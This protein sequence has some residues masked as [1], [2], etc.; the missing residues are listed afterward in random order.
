VGSYTYGSDGRSYELGHGRINVY[1]AILEL[2]ALYPPEYPKNFQ[3]FGVTSTSNPIFTWS[4]NKEA[5]LSGY[6]IYRSVWRSKG[7]LIEE[8]KK[9]NS[10]LITSTTY[11]DYTF[12]KFTNSDCYAS[13]YVVAVDIT[14]RNSDP[15]NHVNVKGERIEA[16]VN[17]HS[18]LPLEWKLFQNCPNPFNPQ[19]TINYTLPH[20]GDVSLK[21]YSI[22][23]ELVKTLV[24]DKQDIG[25]YTVLWNGKDDRNNEVASGIYFYTLQVGNEYKS[26][27]KMLLLK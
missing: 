16:L 26:T 20:D 4:Q 24:N 12:S 27:R 6:N 5:D 2:E 11:T 3:Y 19:T 9:L 15:S 18:N 23:G 14:N 17:L 22:T 7:R 13:Y 1:N 25:Y 21:I 10:S 8:W